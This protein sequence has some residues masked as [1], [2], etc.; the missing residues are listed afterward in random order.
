MTVQSTR[1]LALTL[2]VLILVA[3][4]PVQVAA[5]RNQFD[6]RSLLSSTA[7][8]LA[9][10]SVNY[11]N[12]Y[13]F[14]H[15][16][17]V[18]ISNRLSVAGGMILHREFLEYGDYFL[19]LRL[20]YTMPVNERLYWAVTAQTLGTYYFDFEFDND[21]LQL[22]N[23]AIT[24]TSPKFSGTLTGGFGYS[25]VERSSSP[26]IGGSFRYTPGKKGVFSLIAEGGFGQGVSMFPNRVIYPFIMGAGFQFA[27][28]R[29]A[30]QTFL[31]G[32]RDDYESLYVPGISARVL[33]FK[34]KRKTTQQE[35]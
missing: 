29:T 14:F 25:P 19:S 1:H 30:I 2:F 6:H 21:A 5:Q 12:Y 10:G 13:L 35:E 17:E 34:P 22:L 26:V 7:A 15:E 20:R 8:P 33:L 18:A 27:F 9:K 23:S 24:Y 11:Y 31:A 16:A 28:R 4:M 3:L 32:T